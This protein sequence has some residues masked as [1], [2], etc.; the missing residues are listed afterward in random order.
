MRTRDRIGDGAIV[1]LCMLACALAVLAMIDVAYEVFS[2]AGSAYSHFG[3]GFLLHTGWAPNFNRFGGAV[4]LF[5]TLVCSV[6]A[7]ALAIPIGVAIALFLSIYAPRS[8]RVVAGPLVEL[9]AA[10]P[11]VIVG[12]WGVIVLGP[13]VRTAIEPFL[14]SAFGFLP[15]FG[16]AATT[17]SSLFTAGLVL[18]L[19]VVPIIASLSRD[20]FLAVPPELQDGATALGSTRWEVIRGVVLPTSSPGVI[21]ASFLGL[22]RALGEAIAVAEVCGAGS[23]IQTS[24]FQPGNTLASQIALQ[25]PSAVSP[26]HTSAMFYLA[27]ILLVIGLITNV[28]AQ[29]ISRRFARNLGVAQ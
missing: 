9:L 27:G 23:I 15:I 7:L 10:V 21:A 28:S 26:L 17:G 1:G 3:L 24:L 29:L 6:M 4:F 14:H 25:F 20:V 12:L 5:G 11:S 13:V 19:M 2:G 22:G 18:T 8:V 16:V